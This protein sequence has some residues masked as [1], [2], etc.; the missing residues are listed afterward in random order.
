MLWCS[1]FRDFCFFLHS[2]GSVATLLR[3]GGK[4]DK[5]FIAGTNFLMNPIVKEFLESTNIWQSYARKIS[6]VFLTHSVE[7]L[8]IFS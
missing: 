2:Q 8:L 5:N 6:L 7:L 1:E 3:C 4:I